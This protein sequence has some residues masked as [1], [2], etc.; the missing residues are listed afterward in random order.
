MRIGVVG[1]GYVGLVTAAVLADR[2]HDVVGVDVDGRKVEALKVGRVPI[3]EPGLDDLLSENE[4]RLHFSTDYSSLRDAELAFVAVSTP[5]VDGKIKLDYVLSAARSLSTVLGRDA[6]VAI[7][8]TVVPGTARRVRSVA[9]RE[10]VSNPEFLKEGSAIH[11]TLRPDRVVI[12]SFSASAGDLVESL[13]SFTGAPVLRLTPE[14]AELVKYASN[15]FLALKVSFINEIADVCERL[16]GCDV[17]RVARAIGLDRRISPHFL[18]AGLGW[19]GSCFPKDTRAFLAFAAQLGEEPKTVRA[20]V[21]G[22][23]ERPRRAVRTLERLAGPLR[24]RKVCV[25]GLAFKPN[26]DD[27]RESVAMKVVELLLREGARVVAYDPKARIDLSTSSKE[28]CVREAEAVVI[29]TEWDEFRG[30]EGL[31]KGKYVLDGR[32]VLDPALMDPRFFRAVGL[33]VE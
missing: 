11:D 10:V 18:N 28:E 22:N 30:I 15:S 23:E 16:P 32:R 5:T 24:G 26:T 33:G 31:L 7:K 21:E 13:W 14:E 29:A 8:S 17:N 3:F 2:G 12:G 27:T 6:V 1:L 25:L 4:E 19:G 9:D 20:A